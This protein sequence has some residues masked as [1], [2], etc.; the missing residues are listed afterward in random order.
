M[1]VAIDDTR[2]NSL[3]FTS[4]STNEYY[5][6]ITTEDFL[7]GAPFNLTG[8]WVYWNAEY[9]SEGTHPD[10]TAT[11]PNSFFGDQADIDSSQYMNLSQTMN[12]YFGNIQTSASSWE[13][14][15]N[16]DCI[17]AYSNVFVSSRRNVVLVSSAKN[18]TN[19]VLKYGS[20][21]MSADL[22]TNWWICSEEG[23]DGGYLTCNPRDYISSASSWEVWGYPIEYCLS[24]PTEDICSVEFS[25]TIM[26]VVVGFNALKVIAMIWILFRFDAENILTSVGDAAASFLKSEDQT[27][28]LMCLANKRE[29]RKFWQSRGTAMPF[30][31][32][33]RFWGSAVSKKRWALFFFL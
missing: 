13:R 19:S 31:R 27:T 21:D 15:E 18:D 30:S 25:Q 23:Q 5:W 22:D 8:D 14:L 10:F 3:V 6:I 20:S 17:Q 7:T 26:F 2:Y 12:D 24:Q 1:G 16:K 32:R 9:T 4:L 29:M 33:R 11:P 28:G